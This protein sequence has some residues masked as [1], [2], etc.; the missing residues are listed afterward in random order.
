[1]N[2]PVN[3]FFQLIFWICL[4]GALSSYVLYPL[5][6][7][8]LQARA[9]KTRS[10][11]GSGG[12][13]EDNWPSLSVIIAARNEAERLPEKLDDV[14]CQGYPVDR[15]QVIVVSDGSTD[16]TFDVVRR[17]PDSRVACLELD[18]RMGKESAQV[19]GIQAANGEILVFTDVSTRIGGAGLR[20]IA[21]AF[22][23]SSVGAASSEDRFVTADGQIAG[24]GLYVRY[25]MWLRR[26]ESRMA[27]LVGVS[28]SLFAARR[29]LCD[30]W[31]TDVPSDFVVA[32]RCARRG[33][34][35]VSL[36][37]VFG[38][39]PDLKRD[40]AEFARKRRTAIR[41][42]AGVASAPEVLDWRRFGFFAFQV[43]MHKLV[44]WAVPWFMLGAFVSSLVLALTSVFFA[45]VFALQCVA[46]GVTILAAF[47]P[48]VRR[49]MPIRIWYY[50][51]VSNMALAAAAFDFLRGRRIVRWEP[52]AR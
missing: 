21:T 24:E 12:Y 30:E 44:R 6:L 51:V 43:W 20:G 8:A 47:A 34:R 38:L 42:M 37:S 15:L 16:G 33:Q 1:V 25:E 27:G 52:S 48:A 10:W 11:E 9:L 39:Y 23:D 49:I 3:L 7:H 31:P 26:M 4:V 41:G 5:V 2:W 50:F 29:E 36:P 13:D 46:Y 28:G 32:L 17:Y 18:A 22:A 19:R 35:A 14:F 45:W 40:S